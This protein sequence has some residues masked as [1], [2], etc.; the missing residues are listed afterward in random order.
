LK[1]SEDIIL[2]N[3]RVLLRP[4]QEEDFI[5]LAPFAEKE[6]EIWKYST[7]DMSRG[8]SSMHSYLD[9][10]IANREAGTE[11]PFIVFDKRAGKYAGCTRFY[12]I[13]PLHRTVQLGYTWYGHKFQGS[14]LNRHCKFLLLQFAFEQLNMLRVE[15]RADNRNQRSIAAMKAIGCVEE[16]LLRNHLSLPDGDRRDT[17]ILSIVKEEWESSVKSRLAAL[18]I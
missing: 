6:P 15:F 11:Y 4:L 16:G 9:T 10:A 3:Q 2:Q 14:G 18:C 8:E 13:Q 7:I 17:I 12:D 1:T 5:Q